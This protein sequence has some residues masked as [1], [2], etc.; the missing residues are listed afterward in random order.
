MRAYGALLLLLRRKNS[1]SCQTTLTK[2]NIRAY[3]AYDLPSV[4]ALVRYFHAAAG[5]LIMATW[6]KA[7]KVVNCRT[8]PGLTLDN[9]MAYCPS[10]DETIKRCIVQLR[11]GVRSTKPKIPRRQIPDTSPDESPLPSTKS[12]EIHMHTVHISRLYNVIAY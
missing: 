10:T 9:A 2:T 12:R 3:S 1:P 6:L 11:K 4:E 5:C 7:I 8:W